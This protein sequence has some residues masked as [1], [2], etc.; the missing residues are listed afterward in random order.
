MVP[1]FVTRLK[2]TEQAS[3]ISSFRGEKIRDQRNSGTVFLYF[4]LNTWARVNSIRQFRYLLDLRSRK[5]RPQ[6][7][8]AFT[9]NAVGLESKYFVAAPE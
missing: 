1:N 8:R 3:S 6:R 4:V 2:L 9:E 5:A 7:Q